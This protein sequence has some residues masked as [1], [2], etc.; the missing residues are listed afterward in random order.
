MI[1][2][3][4][5]DSELDCLVVGAGQLFPCQIV[6]SSKDLTLNCRYHYRNIPEIPIQ[7]LVLLQFASSS[8][9]V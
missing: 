7:T 9:F 2:H 8:S 6:A 3:Q 4:A 1:L 5:P